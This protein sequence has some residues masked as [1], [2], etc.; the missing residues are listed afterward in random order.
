[1]P[2]TVSPATEADAASSITIENAAYAGGPLDGILYPG[3]FPPESSS[4][5]RP[6]QL[7][8]EL[9]KDPT[10][11]FMKIEDTDVTSK[12]GDGRIAFAKWLVRDADW[13]V[14]KKEY[15]PGAN[16]EAC[17]ILFGQMARAYNERWIGKPH[18]CKSTLPTKGISRESHPSRYSHASTDLKLL[19]TDPAQQGRGA[20]SLL[21]KALAEE[22]DRLGL[23]AYLEATK[24]A[25]PLYEKFGFKEVGQVSGDFSRWGGPTEH[26]NYLMVREAK[27]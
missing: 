12:G 3:P 11:R 2:L 23:P 6:A 22:T 10:I 21:L 16:L 27:S 7:A 17:E 5:S 13:E 4:S 14:K 15:G 9:R 18:V 19:H 1:M 26:V 8:Q 24:V 20:G 25:K